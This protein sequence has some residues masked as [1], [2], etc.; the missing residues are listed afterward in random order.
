MKKILTLCLASISLFSIAQTQKMG[1]YHLDQTYKMDSKGTI[2]LNSSDA[3]VFITGSN[4]SDVH[5]KIDR[6]VETRGFVFGDAEFSIDVSEASGN[7][8]IRERRSSNSIGVV[9]SIYEKYTITVEAPA[10]VSLVL[11]GD[12]GDYYVKTVHGS[13]D[14]NVDDADVELTSC[15]GSN[16]KF[17]LDDGDIKM[18]EGKGT[19]DVEADDADVIIKNARFTSINADMDDGDFLVETSLTDGGDYFINSQDGLISL[20]VLGGG[21]KFDIRHDDARV[22]TTGGFVQEEESE[23]RTKLAL[24]S[25]TARVD[26]RADDARIKLSV[27]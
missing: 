7:L 5:V 13:M 11:R 1:D 16:F 20:T 19:L 2:T 12:D 4:R 8:S 18:D 14:I 22:I 21:G 9:G 23:N 15:Q 27:Q 10:G 24:A 25:G 26:I 17:R 3:N 6:V